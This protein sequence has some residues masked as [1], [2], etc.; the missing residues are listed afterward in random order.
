[1]TIHKQI[2]SAVLLMSVFAPAV[3][4]DLVADP[5]EFKQLKKLTGLDKQSTSSGKS[6]NVVPKQQEAKKTSGG[7]TTA[8]VTVKTTAKADGKATKTTSDK[9]TVQ[10]STTVSGEKSK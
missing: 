6:V 3:R 4:A 1:M 10:S 2:V 9:T 8:K 7:K 5:N